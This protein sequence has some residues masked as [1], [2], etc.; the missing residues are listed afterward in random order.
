MDINHN[1]VVY[2]LEGEHDNPHEL[3][4]QQEL[5]GS[6]EIEHTL[7]SHTDNISP[8][9]NSFQKLEYIYQHFQDNEKIYES[10]PDL[11]R[12][13]NDNTLYP[14]INNNIEYGLFEDVIN[15][16]YLDSQ[17]KDDFQC[18][19]ECY[20]DKQ[21]KQQDQPLTPC[22]HAYNHITQHINNLADPM[23]QT[24]LY[25]WEED[26]TDTA[27]PCNYNITKGVPNSDT[28][29]ENRSKIISPMGIHLQSKHKYRNVFGDLNIQCHD[30]NNGDALTFK[31]KYTALLQQELQN[32]YWCLHDPITTKSY[33]ISSKMNVETMSHA[34]YFSG[35]KETIAKM[36]QVLYQTIEY[37]DKGMFQVKLMD[38][39]Q[40]EIFIDNGA[41]PSILPLRVYN[42]H[43]ILQK[44]PKIESHTPIYTGGGMIESHFWIEIPLKLDNLVIQ[45]K[46]LVCDSECPYNIVLGH[47][48]LAQL[49]AWQDYA[50]R[51]LYIQQISM[52]LVAKNNVRIL[53][54]QTGIA[55]LVLK[56]SKTSFIPCHTITGKGIAYVR[57]LDLTL[58]LRPVEIEFENNICCL[59]VFNTSD[60]TIEFQYSHEVV[61]FDAR[62]KGLVQINN[63][64]HFPID[65]Y[66]HDRV[67]PATLSPKLIAY[68]KPTKP[69]EMACISTCTEMTTEDTNVSTQDDKYIWLDSDDKR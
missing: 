18:D 27:A 62:S 57:P 8:E 58:P 47:T 7:Y 28:I 59:E 60:S 54:R 61:Y 5:A 52:P 14:Y 12:Y 17:I 38:N 53:P 1:Q 30:F 21:Q 46:T 67:T 49:S 15:S 36:N 37:D 65:Q 11:A 19:Q 23:Q 34:M 25:T 55:S 20:T 16:Y 13:E 50:S 43:P 42:K 40:V 6:T 33:Q 29:S 48:S 3:L 51:Q 39:T 22:T 9:M 4:Q 56:S 66:L 31:D 64:K 63:T 2:I 69:A 35:N 10:D 45:I 32:H 26:A 68:D 41:T 44:Y 24:T